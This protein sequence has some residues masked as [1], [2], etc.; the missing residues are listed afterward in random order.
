[1]KIVKQ[2]K[3][4][5]M[6]IFIFH[7]LLLCF[8]LVQLYINNFTY[9]FFN[10]YSFIN[11]IVLFIIV[12]FINCF[13]YFQVEN[14]NIFRM[15][16]LLQF[17][18]VYMICLIACKS[19]IPIYAPI[20]I[21][22][23]VTFYTSKKLYLIHLLSYL[24]VISGFVFYI[25]YN[26]LFMHSISDII[27]TEFIIHLL[28]SLAISFCLTH[29]NDVI[30]HKLSDSYFSE[31][32]EILS[33][34]AVEES[35]DPQINAISSTMK[36]L[37]AKTDL[38]N[39]HIDDL[40]NNWTIASTNS[41]SVNSLSSKLNKDMHTVSDISKE[42]NNI[43]SQT[44]NNLSSTCELLNSVL[45]LSLNINSS[46][47]NLNDSLKNIDNNTDILKD[48]LIELENLSVVTTH[49]SN[50][51]NMEANQILNKDVMELIVS[52]FRKYSNE[53][54][55]KIL[56]MSSVFN[57][58]N[59]NYYLCKSEIINSDNLLASNSLTINNLLNSI[60]TI[61]SNFNQI[62]ANASMLESVLERAKI[63]AKHITAD[64]TELCYSMEQFGKVSF[65]LSKLSKSNLSNGKYTSIKYLKQN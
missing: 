25:I 64:S 7:S 36:E 38:I 47:K 4:I 31:T 34:S 19:F 5:D 46:H 26:S 18:I 24:G 61:N 12:F 1:M 35:L 29:I 27:S 62:L 45:R 48:M 59:T 60:D 37:S 65:S 52:E 33:I 49:L 51:T 22:I 32:L 44:K 11:S 13:L 53:I 9:D 40:K 10:N 8:M 20:I 50:K 30:Y 39:K 6:I 16:I 63:S 28:L 21:L 15:A 42:L 3:T 14:P 55:T 54:N 2:N 56:H 23:C 43:T 57:K 58:I 17:Y 41:K